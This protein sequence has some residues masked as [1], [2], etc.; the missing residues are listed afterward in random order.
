MLYEHEE[1]KQAS[2]A[3]LSSFA[4]FLSLLMSSHSP[5][6]YLQWGMNFRS[7]C[8]S[9]KDFNKS[10]LVK[11]MKFWKL[12]YYGTYL[13]MK[14]AATAKIRWHDLW[15]NKFNSVA[16]STSTNY[17]YCKLLS[18][19]WW[20]EL[21][22]IKHHDLPFTVFLANSRISWKKLLLTC[23]HLAFTRTQKVS[24]SRLK[25]WKVF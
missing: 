18:D 19:F 6:D 23:S 7:N 5:S 10:I 11:S 14:W 15:W 22:A 8:T 12:N 24:R 25:F 3:S 20:C 16:T 9:S 4:I 1:D 13:L 17:A 21:V 2:R